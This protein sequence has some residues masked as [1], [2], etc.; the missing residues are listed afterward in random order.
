MLFLCCCCCYLLPGNQGQILIQINSYH[1]YAMDYSATEK[2]SSD[3][4]LVTGSRPAA[5]YLVGVISERQAGGGGEHLSG[6]QEE[7]ESPQ[8]GGVAASWLRQ[9]FQVSAPLPQPCDRMSSTKHDTSSHHA[10]PPQIPMKPE[11]TV[12]SLPRPNRPGDPGD[13][14]RGPTGPRLSHSGRHTQMAGTWGQQ[15]PSR[16]AV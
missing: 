13:S 9:H 2:A 10:P 5:D 3:E 6:C 16:P 8:G 11:A 4:S 7:Q 14:P 12:A 1:G 15:T